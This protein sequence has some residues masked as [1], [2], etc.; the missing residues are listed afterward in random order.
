CRRCPP[1][2]SP[3]DG[4]R[5]ATSPGPT[6]RSSRGL[7]PSQCHHCST[8]GAVLFRRCSFCEQRSHTEQIL[9]PACHGE[10]SPICLSLRGDLLRNDACVHHLRAA[11]RRRCRTCEVHHMHPRHYVPSRLASRVAGG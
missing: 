7:P 4:S 6:G 9:Q 1:A 3:I 10:S 8:W 5:G 11:S 2:S